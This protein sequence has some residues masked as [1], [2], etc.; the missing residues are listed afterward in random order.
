MRGIGRGD[1]RVGYVSFGIKGG[2]GM[3]GEYRRW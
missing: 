1:W 3:V 2:D